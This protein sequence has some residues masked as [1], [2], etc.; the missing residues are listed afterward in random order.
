[1]TFTVASSSDTITVTYT[2][3][4]AD[5]RAFL[6]AFEID[7]P[8]IGNQISFPTPS[9]KDERIELGGKTSVTATWRKPSGVSSPTYNVY[10]GTSK[11]SLSSVAT[12]LSSPSTT[13]S[14][15]HSDVELGICHVAHFCIKV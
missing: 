3:S 12:G 5:G 2:P 7:G 1:L 6:N 14:G 9:H 4:G 10:L 15:K 11:T 13:L 8:P